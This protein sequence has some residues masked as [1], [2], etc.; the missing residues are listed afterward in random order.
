MSV[1]M[2]GT[3]HGLTLTIAD[4]LS[5]DAWIATDERDR[6]WVMMPLLGGVYVL[7]G[8]GPSARARGWVAVVDG[9][10]VEVERGR[11]TA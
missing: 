1:G 6:D 9:R 7:S 8:L 2:T 4:A 3:V 10:L 11:M 5:G